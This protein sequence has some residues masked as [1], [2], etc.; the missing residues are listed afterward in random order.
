[1]GAV[2]ELSSLI[3]MMSIGTLTAYTLVALCVLILRYRKDVNGA[4]DILFAEPEVPITP[5][6]FLGQ[7]L[8]KGGSSVPTRL[9]SV[10]TLTAAVAYCEFSWTFFHFNSLWCKYCIL[11]F[12]AGILCFALCGTVILGEKRGYLSTGDIVLVALLGSL[13]FVLLVS[14][15]LQPVSRLK[16]NFTVG[17][18]ILTRS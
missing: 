4:D 13:M 1:M 18:Y 2:F 11:I 7:I 12:I 5:G 16:I 14:L 15:Q 3:D 8:N 9:S 17:N 10:Y 6:G